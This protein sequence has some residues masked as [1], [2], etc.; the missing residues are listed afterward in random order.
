MYSEDVTVC[1]T[2][3]E[4]RLSTFISRATVKSTVNFLESFELKTIKLGFPKR[5][6]R[7]RSFTDF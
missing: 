5:Q 2:Q 4:S 6:F 7:K 3:K 1:G